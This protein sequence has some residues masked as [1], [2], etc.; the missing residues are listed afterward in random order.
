MI[1]NYRMY[2]ARPILDRILSSY[3]IEYEENGVI[4]SKKVH[5][6]LTDRDGNRPE[7]SDLLNIPKVFLTYLRSKI[8]PILDPP[9]PFLN[10]GAASFLASILSREMEVIEFGGGNSTLWFL[11]QGVNLT[12]IESDEKWASY[13]KSGI[14]RCGGLD[15]NDMRF[16]FKL[17]NM[18]ET[19][20]FLH[21]N[22]D[23]SFDL[24]F[25]DSGRDTDR[26][27]LLEHVL[28]K[29]R[30]GGWICFDNTDHPDR[31]PFSGA[32]VI[33][34][35]HEM[36]RFVGYSYLASCKITQTCFWHLSDDSE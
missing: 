36:K 33:M 34:R 5:L 28:P 14:A 17:L 23:E 11:K 31:P 6:R 3:T 22:D 10:C 29:V 19:V 32:Q 16:N 8:N 35:R 26:T 27:V 4:V 30:K 2:Y 24:A 21:S 9:V 7:L 20:D 12:T 15:T 18:Q 25:I 1:S 13:I